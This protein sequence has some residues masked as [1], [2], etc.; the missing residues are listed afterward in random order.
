MIDVVA[1]QVLPAVQTRAGAK[2]LKVGP[3]IKQEK[4]SFCNN[5]NQSEKH[6]YSD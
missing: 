1:R 3:E 4:L 6:F 2:A 5:N